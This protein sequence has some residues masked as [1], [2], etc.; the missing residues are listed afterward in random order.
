MQ[1]FL[2][3]ALYSIIQLEKQKAEEFN[4]EDA[5][6]LLAGSCTFPSADVTD[7]NPLAFE[8]LFPQAN[9]II[10]SRYC[11]DIASHGPGD[12]PYD[13]VKGVEA[14]WVPA[15]RYTVVGPEDNAAVL[16]AAGDH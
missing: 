12:V 8:R 14:F 11:K 2:N 6:S 15:A 13:V 7:A 9:F 5:G 16:R 10:T 3:G 4:V 1:P